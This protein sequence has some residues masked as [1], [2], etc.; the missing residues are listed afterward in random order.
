MLS[1]NLVDLLLHLLD[2]LVEIFGNSFLMVTKSCDLP[3]AI[4]IELDS[5]VDWHSGN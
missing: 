4:L 2:L 3:V 5:F 1:F